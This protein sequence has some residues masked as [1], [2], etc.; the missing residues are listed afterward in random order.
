VSQAPV[1]S[2]IHEPLDIHGN[3]SAKVALDLKVAFD[4]LANRRNVLVVQILGFPGRIQPGFLNDLVRTGT[5][6]A[7]NV[8]EGDFD[9]FPFRKVNTSDASQNVLSFFVGAKLLALSLT[10]FV[11]RII[12][13]HANGTFSSNDLAFD[14]NFLDRGSNFH[15]FFLGGSMNAVRVILYN[16]QTLPNAVRDS[17]SC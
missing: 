10:L 11:F 13:D 14:T 8:R 5:S 17:P 6:N 3:V 16:E 2:E 15:L 12:T 7:V 9:T 4:D 1:R